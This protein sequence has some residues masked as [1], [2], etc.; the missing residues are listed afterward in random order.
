MVNL[1][2]FPQIEPREFS[3]DK[4][5]PLYYQLKEIIKKQIE[6]REL[7]ARDCLPSEREY[8][9]FYKISRMTV[10]QA[11]TELVNEGYLYRQQGK[12]TYVAEK[13]IEQGL[14]QLTSFTEDM[15]RRGLQPSAKILSIQEKVMDEKAT[16]ALG[17]PEDEPV[18][19]IK[20]LRLADGEPMAL[21][22]CHLSYGKYS[23][24][25]R[26]D[27]ENNS[28]YQ[29]LEKRYSIRLNRATQVIEPGIARP[30]VAKLLHIRAGDPIL[31][32]ER[33]TFDQYDNPVEFVSSLYRGDRYKFI[34]E[35]K[36]F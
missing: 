2:S 19:V 21:E 14:M 30:E 17:L 33:T 34:V 18:I 15:L 7:K 25:L 29:F 20:R 16:S 3:R 32:L 4:P 6:T 10:R 28:L 23:E 27:L 26:E 36:K 1:D 31:I 9:E 35:L 5:I 8:S 24:I 11:I 22:T 13:K 12:G